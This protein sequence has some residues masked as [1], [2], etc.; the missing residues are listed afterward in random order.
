MHYPNVLWHLQFTVAHIHLNQLNNTF[1]KY[2]ETCFQDKNLVCLTLWKHPQ[3]IM[4][5]LPNSNEFSAKT[6]Q[7]TVTLLFFTICLCTLDKH[8]RSDVILLDIALCIPALCSLF[9][10][11]RK[12]HFNSS[13]TF[14]KLL[15]YKWVPPSVSNPGENSTR[16]L[17]NS[18]FLHV[19]DCEVAFT[20]INLHIDT[21]ENGVPGE[22]EVEEY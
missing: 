18:S 3:H 4:Y 15:E 22:R 6:I 12:S 7:T 8:Y 11:Q 5:F 10:N 20:S 16:I 9:Q 13:G 14:Q 19:G 2:G 17:P 1:S 21:Q